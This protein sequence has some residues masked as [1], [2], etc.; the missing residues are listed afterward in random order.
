MER[1]RVLEILYDKIQDK[2]RIHTAKRVTSVENFPTHA[3]ITATDGSQ[4]Q[5]SIVVGADGV[6]SVVR[7]AINALAPSLEPPADCTPTPTLNFA[8]SPTPS[9][10]T[11][12]PTSSTDTLH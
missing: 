1:Q 7:R 2:S 11:P 12:Y 8:S 5:A 3:T 10:P 6:H 9:Q 4:L